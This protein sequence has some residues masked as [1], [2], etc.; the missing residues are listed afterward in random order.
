MHTNQSVARG[1]LLLAMIVLLGPSS[2]VA[3]SLGPCEGPQTTTTTTDV[4]LFWGPPTFSTGG[5]W[6]LSNVKQVL[7]KGISVRICERL[8]VGFVFGKKLWLRIA[9]EKGEGWISGENTVAQLLRGTTQGERRLKA[10]TALLW[11]SPAYAEGSAASTPANPSQAPFYLFAFIALLMGMA[12]K[13]LF[14]HVEQGILLKPYLRQT[15][16]AF[17]VSPMVFLGF[18]QA[19]NIPL[20]DNA[21]VVFLC[22]A[23]Q[24][25]FFWQTILVKKTS[26]VP[27]PVTGDALTPA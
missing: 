8:W 9:S 23:F 15:S 4:Q 27:P 24:N 18:A 6:T 3:Q 14:D 17:I 20:G 10:S 7:P 25:G 13:G 16:K 12:M 22:F 5:S 26:P 11:I 19:G 1:L 21:F 2:G